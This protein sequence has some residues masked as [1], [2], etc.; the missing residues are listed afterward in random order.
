MLFRSGKTLSQVAGSFAGL[1]SRP[2]GD[3]VLVASQDKARQ[4]VAL[5]SLD[6][7]TREWQTPTYLPKRDYAV[8]GVCLYRDQAST[9]VHWP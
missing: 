3:N 5:F 4:Q 6:P 1:D 2:L 8:N 9:S 7:K